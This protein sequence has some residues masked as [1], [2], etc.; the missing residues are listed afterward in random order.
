MVSRGRGT[1]VES[2]VWLKA[3]QLHSYGGWEFQEEVTRLEDG[4]GAEESG[5]A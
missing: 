4:K 3:L 5:A 2:W 1:A